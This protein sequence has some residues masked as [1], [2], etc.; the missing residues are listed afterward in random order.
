MSGLRVYVCRREG[1]SIRRMRFD[2]LGSYPTLL[3]ETTSGLR[4]RGV[5]HA[6]AIRADNSDNTKRVT[7]RTWLNCM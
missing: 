1:R 4:L 3:S 6:I 2:L 7:H 5:N